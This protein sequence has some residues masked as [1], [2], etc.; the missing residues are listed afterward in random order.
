MIVPS[1]DNRLTEKTMLKRA[2]P[3]LFTLAATAL[4]QDTIEWADGTKTENCNVTD[5]TV[6]EIKFTAKG[7]R[8]TKPSDQVVA[9]TVQR[10]KDVYRRAFSERETEG[11]PGQFISIAR[12]ELK[13]SPFIA[14]FGFFEAANALF[15]TDKDAD[16]IAALDELLKELPEAGLAPRA[17]VAKIEF[18]LGSDKAKSAQKVAKDYNDMATTKSYP[19]GFLRE[20]EFYMLMADAA[21]GAMKPADLR[22][23]LELM[24]TKVDGKYP[25]LANEC[26]LQIAHSLRAD[27][28]LDDAAPIYEK[29]AQAK[30]A[31]PRVVAG[32]QLGM[33]HVNLAKGTPASKDPYRSALL[34]FLRVYV[35]TQNSAPYLAAEALYYGGEAAKRWGGTDSAM[36]AARLNFILTR[37]ARFSGSEWAKR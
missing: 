33:G 6:A 20:S 13:S 34:S 3:L 21:A 24:V 22:T 14:Q 27:N 10:V 17:F 1:P 18:Y 15:E 16:A 2:V 12:R 11:G 9:V 4:A 36:M 31:T 23:Q 19:D 37:D 35:E 25:N 29:L 7:T 26:R 5:Y 32:A 30:T 8:E 28:K